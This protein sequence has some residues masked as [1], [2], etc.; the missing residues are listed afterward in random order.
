MALQRLRR[1]HVAYTAIVSSGLVRLR[2]RHSVDGA[3]PQPFGQ[4]LNVATPR[5]SSPHGNANV[6]ILARTVETSLCANSTRSSEYE[7][8]TGSAGPSCARSKDVSEFP[9]TPARP[10]P[11]GHLGNAVFANK[12]GVRGRPDPII[13]CLRDQ[14]VS[15]GKRRSST[16]FSSVRRQT[17]SSST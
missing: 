6:L 12:Y 17:T 14:Q 3:R 15:A 9:T 4:V 11:T 8:M 10:W 7:C 16:G 1:R 2:E 5:R 13:S